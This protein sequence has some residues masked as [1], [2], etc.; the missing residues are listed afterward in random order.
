[1]DDIWMNIVQGFADR[2]GGPM[3]FR[4]FLQPVVACALATLAGLKDAQAGKPPYFWALLT[5]P[6]HRKE[7]LKDG[8][9]SV[10]KLFVLAV[11]LDLV[12]QFLV[13]RSFVPREALF[14]AVVIAIVPYLIVR[15]LVNRIARKG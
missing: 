15:G 12:Y 6:A 8:W 11:A 2:F 13:D 4:L 5:D 1:M 10:G 7:M 9:K 3:K 14:V